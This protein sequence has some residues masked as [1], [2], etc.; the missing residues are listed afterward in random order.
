MSLSSDFR[1]TVNYEDNKA[2]LGVKGEVDRFGSV[3]FSALVEAVID[4]GQISVILDL[5]ELQFID[6]AGLGV[7]ASNAARLESSGGKLTVRSPS[8]FLIRLFT[9]TDMS[10]LID[11]ENTEIR[12][13]L[14][15][16]QLKN[17]PEA[18]DEPWVPELIPMVRHVTSIPADNDVVDGALRLVVAL[19]QATVGGA[20]GVSVSLRRH[21][22]LAT[23][24]A[25]DQTILDMDANQYATGEG[26]CVDA[27]VEGRWF[28]IES[29][30]S[31]TRWP[32][33]VPR[34]KE[35]GIN[36]ILSS[37]LIA[38]EQPV[39]ALNIYSRSTGAFH[40][41]DQQLATMF[42]TEASTILRDAGIALTDDQI[43]RRLQDALA[44]RDLIAKA[45]GVIMGDK[46]IFADEAYAV[47]RR[48]SHRTNRPLR[49]CAA[50]VLNMALRS[51]PLP[52]FDDLD[53]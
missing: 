23:V 17:T 1:I 33:F 14:G 41:K 31:E 50:D 52:R 43:A 7:I 19:A 38:E 51:A 22:Q 10:A 29:L 36:S 42:A 16:E 40:P 21:G 27:S 13:H 49:D 11:I 18:A 28:H 24:A 3:E 4:M 8:A 53:E 39:G 48:F 20:D 45:Q 37:P 47:L 46:R 34:A 12:H 32:E 5:S 30:E 25:S 15:P 2:I 26:P 9:I 44:T 35:L 6:A